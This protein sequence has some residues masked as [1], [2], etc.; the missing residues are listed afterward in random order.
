MNGSNIDAVKVAGQ[1]VEE[2]LETISAVHGK[3]YARGVQIVAKVVNMGYLSMMVASHLKQ[4][5]ENFS[6]DEHVNIM[7]AITASIAREVC[8][9]L[10]IPPEKT[11]C[12]QQ[13]TARIAQTSLVRLPAD[14]E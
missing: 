6:T 7:G 4:H 14:Q 11:D 12:F 13:D 10:A 3:D 2:M 5:C 9:A 1:K 8:V